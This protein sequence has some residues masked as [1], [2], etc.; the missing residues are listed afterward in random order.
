M[1]GLARRKKAQPGLTD[2][3]VNIRFL[4][5][6]PCCCPCPQ[7]CQSVRVQPIIADP[8]GVTKSAR[9]VDGVVSSI[10]WRR[11]RDSQL[12]FRSIFVAI[13]SLRGGLSPSCPSSEVP[14]L[15]LV[16]VC[17][18]AVAASPAAAGKCEHSL[19][20][21]G[22]TLGGCAQVRRHIAKR[23]EGYSWR[24]GRTE[25][26]LYFHNTAPSPAGR[27]A[28]RSSAQ[29]QSGDRTRYRRLVWCI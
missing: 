1:L 16:L 3:R 14:G 19:R 24:R 17:C 11:S 13:R 28:L 7:E 6:Q 27:C 25:G 29:Q 4:P 22:L 5:R 8:A 9:V 23:R 21:K 2:P 15:W 26:R 10:V 12:F 18:R 20:C